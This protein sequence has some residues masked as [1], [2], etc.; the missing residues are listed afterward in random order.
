[1]SDQRD[2]LSNDFLEIA[3]ELTEAAKHAEV[4]AKHFS[5]KDVP[6]ACAHSSAVQGHLEAVEIL[7]RE[8]HLIHRKF[9][10]NEP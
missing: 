10:R 8:F 3:R 2:K 9:A 7:I 4:A 6:R 5:N 1:M